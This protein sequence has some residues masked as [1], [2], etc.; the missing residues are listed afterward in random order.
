M[1]H[2]ETPVTFDSGEVTLH[3]VLH[4]A[5]EARGVF[6]FCH[7]FAE[8]K[9]CA[10]RVLVDAARALCDHGYSAL[11]FDYRGC[12]DSE[13]EFVEATPEGWLADIRRAVEFARQEGVPVGLLGVRLGATLAAQVAESL[14]GIAWLALWEPISDGAQYVSQNLRRSMIKAMLTD[15]EGFKAEEVRSAHEAAT[16]DF[17]GYHVAQESRRQIEATKLGEEKLAF[18][19][20]ALVLGISAR[21]QASDKIVALAGQY[22]QGVAGGVRQEPFWNKIGL[23]ESLPAIEAT[24]KWLDGEGAAEPTS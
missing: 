13:G 16:I 11:L 18:G 23:V 20:R 22:S 5:P 9:K 4:R 12:G 17:D 3:G 1:P 15:K 19:G 6:V 10:H 14:P 7:P 24:L 8:E 21:E 2:R